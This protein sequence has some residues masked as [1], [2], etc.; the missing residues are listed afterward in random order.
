MEIAELVLK[1]L[2]A[3]AW[4]GVVL[5]LAVI[6]RHQLADVFK[7]VTRLET[8]AGSLE[9]AEQAMEARE[10][11]QSLADGEP[12]PEAPAEAERAENT[13]SEAPAGA[14]EAREDVAEEGPDFGATVG[15]GGLRRLYSRPLTS[16]DYLHAALLITVSPTAAVEAAISTLELTLQEQL[17]WHVNADLS[18]L[19]G[20]Q[21]TLG[22]LVAEA[23]RLGTPPRTIRVLRALVSLR[24]RVAHHQTEVTQSAA[25]DI[26]ETCSLI[27]R[28]LLRWAG[29]FPLAPDLAP[30]SPAPSTPQN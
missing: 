1:Y 10:D 16:N 5:T 12:A 21:A 25:R 14:G 27:S 29:T 3:L 8:V 17:Q 7:R 19:R 22:R 26:I 30:T 23:D 4:P 13:R 18:L 20:P 15:L 24:N 11:A 2:Q 6:F 28:E 9:F